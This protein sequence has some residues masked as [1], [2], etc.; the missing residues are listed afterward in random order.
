MSCVARVL[1]VLFC[2]LV[3]LFFAMWRALFRRGVKTKV[4]KVLFEMT[5]TF[6]LELDSIQPSQLYINSEKLRYVM[7]LPESGPF[8]VKLIPEK[9][10][11]NQVVFVDGHTRAL[12]AFLLGFSE[13]LVY[14]KDEELD[15]E[16]YEICVEWCK[17]EGISTILDLKNRVVSPRN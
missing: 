15:W 3:L 6:R 17:D 13:V 2:V 7:R 10:L 8:S 4:V 12:V 16:E 14:W 1:V 9:K 5:N 11:G